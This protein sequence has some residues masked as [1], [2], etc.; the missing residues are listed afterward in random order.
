MKQARVERDMAL[1]QVDDHADD[2]WK[3]L[4]DAAIYATAQR[5]RE[6]IS[7]DVWWYAEL[8]KTREDRALGPRMLMAARKGWIVKT[9]RVRPSI[10][11]HASGKPVW[12]SL[13][14]VL[15]AGQRS[16]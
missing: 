5:Y 16:V 3:E 7:D 6:F 15:D 9:D 12:R 8:P 1:G 2:G 4:A 10:R 13:I 11:S 14:H